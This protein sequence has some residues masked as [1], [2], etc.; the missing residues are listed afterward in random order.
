MDRTQSAYWFLVALAGIALAFSY[1]IASPFLR[2][3]FL[4][5]MIAII[6]HP[7]HVWLLKRVKNREVAALLSTILVI[8]ALILPTYGLGVI[9]THEVN[10]M[11][12]WLN[13]ASAQ[14][15]GWSPMV[16]N[17]VERV[18]NWAGRY[19]DLSQFDVKTEALEGLKAVS[20]S[21][22][23]S[24]AKVVNNLFGLIGSAVITFFTLFFLFREGRSMR[25]RI[26]ALLPLHANQVER[27]FNG[28]HDSIIANVN[29][30]LAVGAAQ[31][32]LAGLAFW[33]LGVPSPV[34]WSVVTALFSLIP[35]VGS[36]A[37]WVPAAI[38]LG[39]TGHW[40]K[41]LVLTIWGA[42][43]IAQVDN[44]VRPYIVSQKADLHPLLV[45]FS[46]LGG[47]HAFGVIG[48]FVGP[49]VLSVTLISLDM[50]RDMNAGAPLA[51]KEA[52]RS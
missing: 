22:V 25:T 2:P 49:V 23:T 6:F 11:V 12:R 17:I 38:Y 35:V 1:V 29:G 45:F 19:I 43:V 37:V 34:L 8:V 9:I 31:G 50:L 33:A 30:C 18:L 16:S 21:L 46:L 10:G 41:A 24:G 44:F 51:A 27:L 7:V 26:G 36:A 32:I 5:L 13:Q 14:Q 52:A 47:V 42:V 15:G 40:G 39:T 48:L 3:L 4:A 20:Q 28:I